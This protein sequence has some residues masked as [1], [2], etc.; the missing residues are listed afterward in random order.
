MLAYSTAGFAVATI[1]SSAIAQTGSVARWEVSLDHGATWQ[2]GSV[3]APQSQASVVVRM[4]WQNLLNGTI[5]PAEQWT[6]YLDAA[7]FEAY[8]TTSVANGDTATDFRRMGLVPPG[9]PQLG[10]TSVVTS[11]RVG[12]VLAIDRAADFAP[13]GGNFGVFVQNYTGGVVVSSLDQNIA[14]LQ[15]TLHLD[16]TAGD[17]FLSGLFIPFNTN[18]GFD[19]G[20]NQVSLGSETSFFAADITHLPTTLTI[21][22]TPAT[23]PLL[24]AGSLLV[25]RRRR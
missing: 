23:L 22:P 18:R 6:S 7:T 19:L 4:R 10:L 17:R 20:L 8:S 14:L 11:R 24:A 13:L 1:A 5:T 15:Y 25:I 12:N 3:S 9:I 16:G 21:I 2:N